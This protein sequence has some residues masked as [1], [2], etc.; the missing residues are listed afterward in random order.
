MNMINVQHSNNEYNIPNVYFKY[1]YGKTYKA[2]SYYN[3][4]FNM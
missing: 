2:N 1:V 3:N 4:E